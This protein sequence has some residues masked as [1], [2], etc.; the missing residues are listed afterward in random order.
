VYPAEGGVHECC[1]LRQRREVRPVETQYR[2]KLASFEGP[3]DLLLHLIK[4]EELDIY[5]IPIAHI[6][7]QYLEYIEMMRMLDL[8][9]AGE[10]IVMASDLMRIK[11][12]MLLPKLEEQ[13]EEEMDPRA[14]LVRRLLEYKKYKEVAREL[15]TRETERSGVFPRGWTPEVTDEPIIELREVSIFQLLDI[16]R[17]VMTRFAQETVHRVAREAVKVEKKMEEILAALEHVEGVAFRAFV[18]ECKSKYEV[19]VSFIALLELIHYGRVIVIQ[20]VPFGEILMCRV[21]EEEDDVGAQ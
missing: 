1:A 12:R 11:A 6:T 21:N 4:K 13:D 9:V 10:F 18:E 16:M 3:L 2:I 14:D 15:R 5:D 17:S 7:R 20:K 19:L 8:D